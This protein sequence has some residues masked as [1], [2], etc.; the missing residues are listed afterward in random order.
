M[1]TGTQ[2]NYLDHRSNGR[3][4]IV[5]RV[6]NAEVTGAEEG[7]FKI[8]HDLTEFTV[9]LYTAPDG[10]GTL[11]AQ[12]ATLAISTLPAEVALAEVASS[13]VT[14]GITITEITDGS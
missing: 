2:L 5:S 8:A 4:A 7:F 1:K 11:L 13:G 10:T 3:T 12:S 14:A 6:S 9:Y